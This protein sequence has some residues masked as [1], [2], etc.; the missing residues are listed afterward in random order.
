M[1]LNIEKT[2]GLLYQIKRPSPE[3][4]KYSADFRKLASVISSVVSITPNKRGLVTEVLNLTVANITFVGTIV[5]FD[6]ANGTDCEDYEVTIV[7][8]DT[9]GNTIS[10]D[11]L[12]KV[13]KA[14]LI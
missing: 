12:I 6:L 2:T 7:I 1:L 9:T 4:R 3:Y 5:Y 8:T 13:R 11:I 10:E 14:G